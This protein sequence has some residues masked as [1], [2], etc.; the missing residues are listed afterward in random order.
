MS[1]PIIAVDVGTVRI[2]VASCAGQGLPALPVTT[3]THESR[4]KDVQAIVALARERGARTIIVG[5]PLRLDGT[6]GPAAE[7]MER[8][9]GALRAAF[10]GEVIGVDERMTTAL[11]ARK[12]RDTAAGA[13]HRRQLID[14]FAAVEILESYLARGEGDA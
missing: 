9:I 4:E 3:L 12:L 1:S 11:A 7:K 13:A 6:R 8:F 2:G 5:Y 14:R 10:D